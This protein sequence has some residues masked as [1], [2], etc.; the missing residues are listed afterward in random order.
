MN[1]MSYI[2]KSPLSFKYLNPS[3]PSGDDN[4]YLERFGLREKMK[5][6]IVNRP[7]GTGDWLFM[8]FHTPVKLELNK[9]VEK[10]A[11][12]TMIIWPDN[13]AHYYGNDEIEWGHSWFHCSGNYIRKL[14]ENLHI[15]QTKPFAFSKFHI[16]EKFLK[17]IHSEL[18]NHIRADSIILENIF[19][20]FVRNIKRNISGDE[21]ASFPSIPDNIL[22]VRNFLESHFQEKMNLKKLAEMAYMSKPHFSAEFKKYFARPP[23]DYLIDIRMKHARYLLLDKNLSVAEI[24]RRSGYEDVFHFSKQFKKRFGKS[25]SL[26]RGQKEPVSNF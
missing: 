26:Y 9:Q 15:P 22:K 1:Y 14:V 7:R 16:M 21:S 6:G 12:N 4:F 5:K 23:V 24:S 25:P 19:E 17:D 3:P 10:Q 2:M 20:I 11:E 18:A 8:F 13:A